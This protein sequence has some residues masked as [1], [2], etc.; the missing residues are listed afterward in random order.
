MV[1]AVDQGMHLRLFTTCQL[2]FHIWL[3]PLLL[4]YDSVGLQS[5]RSK[6][7]SFNSEIDRE[8]KPKTLGLKA[9]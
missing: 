9:V 7:N 5:V 2:L 3:W 1:R 4:G 6:S 8:P